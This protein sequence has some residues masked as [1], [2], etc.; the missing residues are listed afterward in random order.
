MLTLIDDEDDSDKIVEIVATDDDD[1]SINNGIVVVLIVI[2]FVDKVVIGVTISANTKTIIAIKIMIDEQWWWLCGNES[3]TKHN[4]LEVK[5]FVIGTCF[6]VIVVENLWLQYCCCRLE[7]IMEW[8]WGKF[9]DDDDDGE[10]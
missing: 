2:D 8:I 10:Q 9:T 3:L 7:T 4:S 6:F 5:L 1:V